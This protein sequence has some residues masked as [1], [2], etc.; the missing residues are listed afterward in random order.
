MSIK[1]LERIRQMMG[2]HWL[3]LFDE[4][5]ETLLKEVPHAETIRIF[6]ILYRATHVLHRDPTA[7]Q[8]LQERFKNL[9]AG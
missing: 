6:D 1:Q 5:M 2:S 4:R 9:C 3:P 8:K 7:I